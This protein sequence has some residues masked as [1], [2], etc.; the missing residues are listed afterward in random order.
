MLGVAARDADGRDC[1]PSRVYRILPGPQAS[2]VVALDSG[3]G[4]FVADGW[5]GHRAAVDGAQVEVVSS[6]GVAGDEAEVTV[7]FEVWSPSGN[8]MVSIVDPGRSDEV[9]V[10]SAVGSAPTRIE[11]VTTPGRTL[12]VRLD[13]LDEVV[14]SGFATSG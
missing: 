3:W 6:E 9:V 13:G 12:V 11:F 10:V 7:S 1:L 2:A 8:G 14:A 4:D 5:G